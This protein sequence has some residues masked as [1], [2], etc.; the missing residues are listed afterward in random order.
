MPRLSYNVELLYQQFN[1]NGELFFVCVCIQLLSQV[2]AL[3]L[4]KINFLSFGTYLYF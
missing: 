2:V 1:V 3:S 4:D